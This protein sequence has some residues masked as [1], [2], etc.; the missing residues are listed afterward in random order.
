MT[1]REREALAAASRDATERVIL[2]MDAAVAQVTARMHAM[3]GRPFEN[4][5]RV[6]ARVAREGQAEY[7][8]SLADAV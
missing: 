7:E 6:V 8:R 3:A 1:D 5:V 2:L 4:M